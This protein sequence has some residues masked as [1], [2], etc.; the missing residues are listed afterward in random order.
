MFQSFIC[1]K[2]VCVCV[3]VH[4]TANRVKQ[5]CSYNKGKFV[6][7]LKMDIVFSLEKQTSLKRNR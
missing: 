5:S 2:C 6:S 4:G 3:Y 7:S 1:S